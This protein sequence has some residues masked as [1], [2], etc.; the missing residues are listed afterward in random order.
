MGLKNCSECGKIY[1]ENPSK[2]CPECY[3]QE[4]EHEH[5]IGEYLREKGK[6]TLE[7]IHEATGVK[8]KIIVRMLK[9]GRLFS[10]G[11]IGYPCEMCRVPI[12]DGRLCT[13]CASGLTKQVQQSHEKRPLGESLDHERTGVR[14]YTKDAVVKK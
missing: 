3:V 10:N 8:E 5:I 11:L 2:L 14:M 9:S 7:E 12:Y 1:V 13:S 4:E 6:A